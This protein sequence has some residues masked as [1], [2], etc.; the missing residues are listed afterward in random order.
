[1][2]IG[3]AGHVDHGKT[4]LVQALTG[5]DTDRLK[6]EKER[7]IS[8]DLGFAYLPEQEAGTIGFVDVPGHERFIHNML[9]GVLGVDYIVFVVAANEGIKP[10]T[11]EHLA[12]LDLLGVSRGLVALT[13]SDLASTA[14][15]ESVA[16][17]I[18]QRLADTTLSS[19]PII[20][21]SSITG[22]GLDLI[23]H[24]LANAA[25]KVEKAAPVG[26]FRLAVDRCFTLAGIGT[27]VTGTALSGSVSVGDHVV[28][29]PSGITAQVR[30]IHAQ[31]RKVATGQAGDRLA[32]NLTGGS[33]TKDAITRG[34]IVVDA[35]LHAPTSRI[36]AHLRLAAGEKKPVSQWMPVKFHHAATEM[37]ARIV[38]LSDPPPA[39]GRDGFVQLVLDR[40]VAATVGDRFIIRDISGRR[41][42]GGGHLVDL[43]APARR[44]RT[45]L[46]MEQLHHHGAVSTQKAMAGLLEVAPYYVDLTAFGRDRALSDS[47]IDTLTN[48]LSLVLLAT[49]EQ[50][51]VLSR[52]RA[53]ELETV[54]LGT[55]E[56]FHRENPD[57]MGIGFEQLRL[58]VQPRLLAATFG[59]FLKRSIQSGLVVL[60]GAWV[61]LA[62]HTLR[63]TAP[64]DKNWR[65]ILPL[66]SESQRFRPPKIRELGDLLALTETDVRRLLKTLAKMGKV[67]EVSHDHF[68]TR[69]ALAEILEIIIDVAGADGGRIATATVRD[70]L[71]NGR[72]ISIE[73]LEFFDRHGVTIRR[74]DFRVLNRQ[75]LDH[76][77]INIPTRAGAA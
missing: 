50:V 68:F 62:S 60:E 32:L 65:R 13:K 47:E 57:L 58:K 46:R 23:R 26:R 64:D 27:V 16:M 36:D 42:L 38:L 53:A 59:E 71:D 11:E 35:Q 28:V 5:V 41:T 20:P 54:L 34:D 51:F 49:R 33:V 8:I 72:K 69:A 4:A 24:E 3:T 77:R 37:N 45:S 15:R 63:L 67:Q 14:Q 9:A 76:F 10:Q 56:K 48:N 61:R 73:L 12:I 39:A 43:R 30:S 74:G 44:R 25:R 29:S 2:I 18:R 40:P 55:L 22:E 1:M 31:N 75:R 21:V 7:G 17:E 19:I 6:A 70:R 66:L 52:P